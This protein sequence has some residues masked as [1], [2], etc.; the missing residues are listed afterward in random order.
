MKKNLLLYIIVLFS[1]NL[2]ADYNSEIDSNSDYFGIT[3]IH[4][5]SGFG[6]SYD[7]L[8]FINYKNK[9]YSKKFNKLSLTFKSIANLKGFVLNTNQT[10]D[11]F[12]IEYIDFNGIGD[13]IYGD[14]KDN[15]IIFEESSSSFFI[16]SRVDGMPFYLNY[17][18]PV[19]Y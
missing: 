14:F 5:E 1:G 3:S 16:L 13:V 18:E 10:R 15:G 19:F 8:N 12:K 2:S 6:V 9:R 7:I 17:L 11:E 4:D